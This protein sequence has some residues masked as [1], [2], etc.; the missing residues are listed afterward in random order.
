[1][2]PTPLEPTTPTLVELLEGDARLYD[3]LARQAGDKTQAAKD[4]SERAARLRAA[5]ARL[6]EYVRMAGTPGANEVAVAAVL[7]I[8]G[9]GPLP[10]TDQGAGS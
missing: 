2:P 1:M 9:G 6:A 7:A 10:T 8:N 5:A 4:Y 3:V